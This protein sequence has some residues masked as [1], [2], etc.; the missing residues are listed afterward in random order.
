MK[1]IFANFISKLRASKISRT[2]PG[3]ALI[4]FVIIFPVL[5]FMIA[6]MIQT[7]VAEEYSQLA[8]ANMWYIMREPTLDIMAQSFTIN[9]AASAIEST[10]PDPNV[11]VE[12]SVDLQNYDDQTVQGFF[13]VI[14][15]NLE[16]Q[17]ANFTLEVKAPMPFAG[18][19]KNM[20]DTIKIVKTA[21]MWVATYTGSLHQSQ[22]DYAAFIVAVFFEVI[23]EIIIG[24][25]IASFICALVMVVCP[26]LTALEALADFTP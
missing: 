10:F 26:I 16:S 22:A 19:F 8:Q 3:Q 7:Y 23:A 17:Q 18:Y 2:L 6:Y 1:N 14:N 20:S 4:E 15:P 25:I 13:A 9:D 12:T 11:K 24:G 5:F 21:Q